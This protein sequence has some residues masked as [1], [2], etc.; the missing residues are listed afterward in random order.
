MSTQVLAERYDLIWSIGILACQTIAPLITKYQPK[1]PILMSS[2]EWTA[3]QDL[4]KENPTLPF[5]A[6]GWGGSCD[7]N[8]RIDLMKLLMPHVKKALLV[9]QNPTL[10]DAQVE[11][12]ETLKG[13]GI[14]VSLVHAVDIGTTINYLRS[15]LDSVDAIIITRESNLLNAMDKLVTLANNYQ[16]PLYV[17]DLGSVTKGAACGIGSDETTFGRYSAWFAKKVLF[18][19]RHPKELPFQEIKDWSVHAGLNITT[20]NLQNTHTPRAIVSLMRQ[21]NIVIKE[22]SPSDKEF[23]YV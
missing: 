22:E 5:Y 6:T 15:A 8:L 23:C 20:M 19:G 4:A 3:L 10:S 11:L 7:W 14:T 2:I 13:K 18:E 12:I 21:R 1:T 16:V 17:S 9:H